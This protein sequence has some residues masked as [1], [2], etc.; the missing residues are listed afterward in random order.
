MATTAYLRISTDKQDE[1][2]QGA[3]C[4]KLAAELG[5]KIDHTIRETQSGGVAW[6]ERALA[7]WLDAA[8]PGDILLLSEISRIA[9]SIT[10]IMS[11]LEAAANRRVNVHCASPR[12][13]VDG[14]IQSS[15]LVFAFGLAA[16]IERDLIRS[17]TR[18]ALAERK[19][20]GVRLGRPPGQPTRSKLDQHAD[21]IR[22]MLGARV[23]HA[24]IGRTFG[25]S[26]QTVCAWVH[27]HKHIEEI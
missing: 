7:T 19:A 27:A 12:F 23:S 2:S 13:A 18:A 17:R 20:A 21:A 25:A 24:A 9:R 6:Q 16:Q 14:S 1:R 22:T 11:F 15:V 4:E 5:I 8:H 26:R 10:G 3:T